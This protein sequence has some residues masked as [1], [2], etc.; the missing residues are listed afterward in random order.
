MQAIRVICNLINKLVGAAFESELR[1]GEKFKVQEVGRRVNVQGLVGLTRGC[2]PTEG[3]EI[4]DVLVTYLVS[5]YKTQGSIHSFLASRH[6]AS[7]PK[8]TAPEPPCQA[9]A[10]PSTVFRASRPLF[11]NNQ[12]S[13]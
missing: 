13:C 6:Q 3:I 4:V 12:T 5:V 1:A 2:V 10:N 9:P 7:N 8:A 11:K